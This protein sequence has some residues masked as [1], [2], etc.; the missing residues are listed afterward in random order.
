MIFDKAYT[1]GVLPVESNILSAVVILIICSISVGLILYGNRK[2]NRKLN[3]LGFA[4]L[5]LGVFVFLDRFPQYANTFSA[6]AMLVLAIAAFMAI[7]ENR[8]LREENRCMRAEDR[9]LD[10]KRRR[11]DDV[12]NWINEVF[13]LRAES[14]IPF[15]EFDT[16]EMKRRASELFRIL[17]NS[18]WVKIEA[19]R[20]DLEVKGEIKLLDKVNRLLF[21][22]ENTAPKDLGDLPMQ[23][24]VDIEKECTEALEHISAIKAKL[25]V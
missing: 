9:E 22:L 8:R 21:I 18:R 10:S 16:V 19:M 17:A 1:L 3:W 13:K 15:D 5:L 6:W 4:L 24:Q 7:D 14:F 2:K 11:V 23:V 25:L 12:Q 20:L